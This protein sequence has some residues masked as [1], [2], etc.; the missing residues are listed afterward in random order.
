VPRKFMFLEQVYLFFDMIKG[1]K[2][3]FLSMVIY[4]HNSLI[5]AGN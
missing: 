4:F 5:F 1:Y 3:V 2:L